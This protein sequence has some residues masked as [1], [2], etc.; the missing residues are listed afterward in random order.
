MLIN[1]CLFGNVLFF[2]RMS[3]HMAIGG[4]YLPE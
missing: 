4:H 1:S 2:N 3:I